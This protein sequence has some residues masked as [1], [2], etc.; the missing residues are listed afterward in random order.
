MKLSVLMENEDH[1][2]TLAELP[3][4]EAQVAWD[5]SE[6]VEQ[7]QEQLRKAHKKRDELIVKYGKPDPADP[8]KFQ[9]EDQAGLQAELDKLLEVDVKVDFPSLKIAQLEGIKSSALQMMA[10]R[11]LKILTK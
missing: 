9:V 5:L 1:L 10:W 7:A 4:N 8:T 6:A 2:K 11:K 3:L